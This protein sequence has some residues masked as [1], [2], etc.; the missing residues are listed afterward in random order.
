MNLAILLDKVAA[1]RSDGE[2]AGEDAVLSIALAIGWGQRLWWLNSP[3]GGG[4]E[5]ET[6]GEAWTPRG[7]L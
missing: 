1:T 6:L 3:G 5:R 4:W 2:H 7:A